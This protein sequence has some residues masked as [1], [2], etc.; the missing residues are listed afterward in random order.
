VTPLDIGAIAVA[1]LL[2]GTINTIVGSGTL[3]TFPVLVALGVPPVTANASNSLG[4]VPGAVSGAY[5]YRRRLI[6]QGR[7]LTRLLPASLSGAVVGALLLLW[8]PK[9]A[10][11]VIVPFL[12]AIAVVLVAVGPWLVRR[13]HREDGGGA[14]WLVPSVGVAGTYGGYFGAA[15]GVILLALL[16]LAGSKDVQVDNAVKNVLAAAA[17]AASA[18]VF[19]ASGLVDWTLVLVLALSSTVGGQIGALVGQRIPATV[20]RGLIISIGTVAFVAMVWR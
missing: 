11:E 5:G 4:L 12:I 3:I 7:L 16:G 15:Q 19:A 10:F 2:A 1:G 17:N 9:S 13:T 14:P 18:V 20:L 8:L 6:G